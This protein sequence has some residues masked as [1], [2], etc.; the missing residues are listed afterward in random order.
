MAITF[1]THTDCLGHLGQKNYE[2]TPKRLEV[3]LTALKRLDGNWVD[4]PLAKNEDLLRAHP[5]SHID[6]MLQSVAPDHCVELDYD[7]AL[8]THT[9]K[10]ISRAVGA[11]CRAVDGVCTG[12]FA[13]A[14]CAV[15]PPGHHAEP[16]RAMGFCYFS[17]IA[18]AAFRARQVHNVERVAVID[19]DVHHGNGTQACL[20]GKEGFYVGSIHQHPHYPNTGTEVDTPNIR[21]IP[22]PG[23]TSAKHWWQEYN[24]KIIKDIHAFKPG[25]ILV[26]AGFDAHRDDPL[27]EFNLTED[28]YSALAQQLSSLANTYANGRLVSVLEGGYNME[29]LANSTVAYVNAL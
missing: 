11:V 6:K 1:I 16:E 15:R 7:T 28:D 17:A 13:Q 9:A 8:D 24:D 18:I 21:N 20:E 2:E 19:F 25:L 10:A 12:E 4:A 5:Q 3:V 29:A 22:L 26:S 27:G 14:F 23:G